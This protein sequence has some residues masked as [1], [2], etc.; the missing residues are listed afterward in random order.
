[1]ARANRI[2]LA[3]IL[4]P[5]AALAS[6]TTVEWGA[7][8]EREDGTPVEISDY[9]VYYGTAL[10]VNE[11]RAVEGATRYVFEPLPAGTWYFNVTAL[12]GAGLESARSVTGSKTIIAVDNP[13]PPIPPDPVIVQDDA[14]FAYII[15]QAE[16]R[17]AL[18]PVGT[19][20][21]GT[22]CDASQAIRDSNGLTAFRVPASAVTW[23]G[24]VRRGLVF[25]PC[26][27]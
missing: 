19:V 7:V 26:G 22:V 13:L 23:S 12:D 1:M 6:E 10:P 15:N 3:L 8:T 5:L 27:N 11:F 17:L 25:S 24:T 20:A 14:Q 21:A 4:L 16:G 9:R 2:A 18:V